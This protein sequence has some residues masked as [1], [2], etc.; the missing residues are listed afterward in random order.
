MILH[1]FDPEHHIRVETDASGYAIGEVLSQLTSDDLGQWHLVAFFSRKMILAETRYETHDGELLA[2][3]EAFKTWRHYLEGSQ[4]EMLVLTDHNN[5]RR[6]METKSLSSR[7]VHWAQKLFRYNFRIDYRQGKANGA[8]DA[9]SQYPQ[10]SV[11][12]E[13]TLHSE[14]VKILHRLQ[15]S[16]AKVSGLSTSQISPL[17]QILICGTTVFPRLNQFWNS[18]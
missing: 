7:Q 8:A 13:K 12:E 17:H 10:Q 4:H 1:H 9:L 15:S 16:L 3:V 2:I 11:E 18:L 6:F 5:L 14:N